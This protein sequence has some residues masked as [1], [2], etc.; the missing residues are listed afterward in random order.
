MNT[1]QTSNIFT[2]IKANK[3][4]RFGA[5]TLTTSN[6]RERVLSAGSYDFIP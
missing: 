5:N 1:S 4:G 3:P 6:V 2:K